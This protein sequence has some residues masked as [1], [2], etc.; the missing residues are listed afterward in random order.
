MPPGTGVTLGGSVWC[1][2]AL[3]PLGLGTGGFEGVCAMSPS[4]GVAQ[5]GYCEGLCNAPKHQFCSF[6][7][8]FGGEPYNNLAPQTLLPQ[9]ARRCPRRAPV[10]LGAAA[11]SPRSRARVFFFVVFF[12]GSP[13]LVWQREV[14]GRARVLPV[15][16]WECAS[17]QQQRELA[18]GATPERH[19]RRR[20]AENRG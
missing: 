2:Q 14:K 11:P 6:G 19:G 7:I 10:L 13:R 15:T 3:G 5:F 17:W 9:S 20:R 16:P 1:L 4:I 8:F 18:L 12:L